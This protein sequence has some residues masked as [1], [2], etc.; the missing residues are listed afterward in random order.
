MLVRLVYAS[1]AVD[2]A[3]EH[4]IAAILRASNDN[5]LE[6]GITGVLCFYPDDHHFLQVL[7]GAREEVNKLYNNIVQ[8][9]RHTEVRL[10]HYAEIQTRMFASWRMGSVDLS[11]VNLST[12]L[13]YSEKPKLD[14]FQLSGEAALALLCEL[15][16]NASVVSFPN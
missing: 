4:V 5:N 12:L 3:S 8:D 10:L 2:P 13:K 7:E 15:L 1:R 9:N 11:K 14:P 6:Y 16:G